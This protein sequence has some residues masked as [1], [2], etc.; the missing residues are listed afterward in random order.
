MHLNYKLPM[1]SEKQ[2]ATSNHQPAHYNFANYKNQRFKWDYWEQFIRKNLPK[3]SKI[4]EIGCAYAYLSKRL[5][6]DY[7]TYAIDLSQEALEI[8]R[9]F[10]TNTTIQQMDAERLKFQ[11]KAF[12]AVFCLDLLEH[13]KNPNACISSCHRILK[14]KGLFVLST[15]NPGSIGSRLK[16]GEWFAYKDKTHISIKAKE[17]WASILKANSFAVISL[18]TEGFFDIPYLK[19]IPSFLQKPLLLPGYLQ[20]KLNIPFLKTGENLVFVCKN[21]RPIR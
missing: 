17:E 11:S 7:E 3:G 6:N 8:A 9:A 12:D 19:H 16:K 18:Y 14:H 13:L 1:N 20:Y 5:E 21:I 4:L 10:C 15:P 2:P